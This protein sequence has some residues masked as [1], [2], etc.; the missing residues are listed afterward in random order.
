MI[1]ILFGFNWVKISKSSQA[2]RWL[3]EA[4]SE[5]QSYHWP[6]VQGLAWGR[7]SIHT[8]YMLTEWMTDLSAVHFGISVTL[9]I[10]LK[11]SDAIS[12]NTHSLRAQPSVN[13]KEELPVGACATSFCAINTCYWRSSFNQLWVLSRGPSQILP[14]KLMDG[15]TQLPTQVNIWVSFLFPLFL[16]E[17]FSIL[18]VF[19]PQDFTPSDFSI[20]V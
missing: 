3:L 9:K 19:K 7:R 18:L 8:R 15:T 12:Y 10:L 2:D 14:N 5:A 13:S 17:E 16:V 6:S 1:D 4:S 11:S 20:Q